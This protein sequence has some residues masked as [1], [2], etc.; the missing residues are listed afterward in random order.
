MHILL[1]A[2]ALL[3]VCSSCAPDASHQTTTASAHAKPDHTISNPS[4]LELHRTPVDVVHDSTAAG[5]FYP[6]RQPVH[7]FFAYLHAH[8]STVP[9]YAATVADTFPRN[10]VQKRDIAFLIQHLHSVR[11]C[12][13]IIHPYSSYIPQSTADE[14]GYALALLNAYRNNTGWNFGLWKCPT[15]DKAEA[16]EILGWWQQIQAA[17]SVQR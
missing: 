10:W 13:C 7:A 6:D 16:D 9:A 2:F 11:P 12:P 4:V 3:L 1:V 17:D 14:G 5:F 8:S 15:Y